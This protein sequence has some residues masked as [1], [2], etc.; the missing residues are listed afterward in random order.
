[1]RNINADL[2]SVVVIVVSIAGIIDCIVDAVTKFNRVK[3]NF[4][5]NF[6]LEVLEAIDLVVDAIIIV[7]ATA[8]DV[9]SG[10]ITI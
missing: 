10:T 7:V 5:I 8:V 4:I 1:M 2:L 6:I 3:I 9:I